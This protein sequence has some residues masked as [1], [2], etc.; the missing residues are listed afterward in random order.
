MKVVFN[1]K[2]IYFTALDADA[3]FKQLAEPV[4]ALGPGLPESGVAFAFRDWK[5]FVTFAKRTKSS[6]SNRIAGR[7]TAQAAQAE[8][9]G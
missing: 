9:R 8:Q 5:E 1:K 3:D 2:R 4:V 7:A 6:R